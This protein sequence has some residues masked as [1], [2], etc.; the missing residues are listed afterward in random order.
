MNPQTYKLTFLSVCLTLGLL[1]T[2]SHAKSTT[3]YILSLEEPEGASVDSAGVLQSLKGLV[4]EFNGTVTHEYSLINGLSFEIDD[5]A[6]T[7]DARAKM[8]S[9]GEKAGVTVNIEKDQDVH[10]FTG[11]H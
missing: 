7:D 1:I 5:S 2:M 4:S 6:F 11:K 10:T 8:V 3:S 9:L